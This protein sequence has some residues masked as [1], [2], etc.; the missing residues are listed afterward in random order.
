MKVC[1][2]GCEGDDKNT[3]LPFMYPNPTSLLLTQ[4]LAT[5]NSKITQMLPF[6]M[7]SNPK[8]PRSL[9]NYTIHA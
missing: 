2:Q 1:L 9:S 7:A 6:A 5:N 4:V 3:I 8:L